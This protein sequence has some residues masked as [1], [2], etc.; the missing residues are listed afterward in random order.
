MKISV[1]GTGMVG[2]AIASRLAELGH[3][4]SIGTRDPHATL[5]RE[6]FA[7]WAGAHPSVAVATFGDAT[8]GADLVVNA[9]SGAVTL[10][11]LRQAGDLARKVV[12]DGSTGPDV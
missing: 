2:Q 11:G 3:D 7:T 8:E 10:D 9:T 1:L 4:V 12:L 6:E 5:G